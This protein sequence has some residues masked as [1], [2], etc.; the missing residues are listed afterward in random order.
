MPAASVT[1]VNRPP[2]PARGSAGARQPASSAQPRKRSG[3]RQTAAEG[4]AKTRNLAKARNGNRSGRG[5]AGDLGIPRAN[6][7]SPAF[8]ALALSRQKVPSIL[9][10]VFAFR[11]FAAKD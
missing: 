3:A 9:F 2:P 6:W 1:S 10:R 7:L 11:A 4:T 8:P 5:L